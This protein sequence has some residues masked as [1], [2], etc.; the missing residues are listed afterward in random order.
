MVV[1]Y[2]RG[3]V[4]TKSTRYCASTVEAATTQMA[5]C[6]STTQYASQ[7]SDNSALMPPICRFNVLFCKRPTQ[8][9][10]RN[11][12]HESNAKAEPNAL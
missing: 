10:S 6:V 12:A 7:K 9:P 4:K 11:D 2:K 8:A 1:K 5:S 3:A